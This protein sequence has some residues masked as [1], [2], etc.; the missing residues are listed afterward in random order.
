MCSVL[1]EINT[2]HIATLLSGRMGQIKNPILTVKPYFCRVIA[3]KILNTSVDCTYHTDVT[4]PFK[5]H[6][7]DDTFE[8]NHGNLHKDPMTN[9]T[10]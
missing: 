5:L 1:I 9:N 4:E 7:L 3:L 6:Y 8:V 10:I 2:M